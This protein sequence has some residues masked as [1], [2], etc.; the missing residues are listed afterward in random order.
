MR[1]HRQRHLNL[2]KERT[3]H[4]VEYVF[5]TEW[6]LYSST[7]KPVPCQSYKEPFFHKISH[8]CF[9]SSFHSARTNA[10]QSSSSTPSV[11]K[12]KTPSLRCTKI[13][14]VHPVSAPPQDAFR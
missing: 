5:P 7:L 8:G 11:S 2:N 9:K 10:C 3:L 13:K 6:N 12:R 1:A 14:C 4:D